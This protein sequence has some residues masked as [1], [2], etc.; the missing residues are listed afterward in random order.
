VDFHWLSAE[1]FLTVEFLVIQLH[2]DHLTRCVGTALHHQGAAP[3]PP[4][5]TRSVD[6]T[7][8][9]NHK[10]HL[11]QRLFKL[12]KESAVDVS[13]HVHR[14]SSQRLSAATTSR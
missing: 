13:T 6:G 11:A 1:L 9:M 5:T 8:Q 14:V 10:D 3:R 7:H 4:G 12:K 2:I